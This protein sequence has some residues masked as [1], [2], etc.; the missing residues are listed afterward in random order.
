M[1]KVTQVR[2]SSEHFSVPYFGMELKPNTAAY[3]K[4][5]GKISQFD[6]ILEG[7]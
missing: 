6:K 2:V 4:D 1:L 5:C 7:L 3:A